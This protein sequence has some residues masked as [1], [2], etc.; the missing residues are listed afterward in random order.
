M[1]DKKQ[2]AVEMLQA[3][4]D[5]LEMDRNKRSL[6]SHLDLRDEL[7]QQAKEIEE[8]HIIDAYV[9]GAIHSYGL[10]EPCKDITDRE[11]GQ[12]HYNE[13]FIS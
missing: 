10:K 1:S 12:H 6:V 5:Q 11:Y 8:Q 4:L 13:T 3:G 2:T 7:F 9:E